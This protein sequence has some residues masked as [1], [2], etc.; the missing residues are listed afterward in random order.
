MCEI[1][2]DGAQDV[3]VGSDLTVNASYDGVGVT[4]RHHEVLDER[5]EP[6]K[7]Q[8]VAVDA[9]VFEYLWC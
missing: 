2:V 8:G 6:Q 5:V 4:E 3:G 9:V 1:A 7:R